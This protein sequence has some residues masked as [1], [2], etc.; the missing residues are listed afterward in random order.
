MLHNSVNILD[1]ILS[2]INSTISQVLEQPTKI[3][4]LLAHLMFSSVKGIETLVFTTNI[5]ASIMLI[6]L[7]SAN[8]CESFLLT[9]RQ[10]FLLPA[11]YHE[12][13]FSFQR[14]ID[15]VLAHLT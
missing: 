4:P 7:L 1:C 2:I 15:M 6:F 5:P 10:V 3:Y 13:F 12:P 9:S 8:S 11:N 14:R